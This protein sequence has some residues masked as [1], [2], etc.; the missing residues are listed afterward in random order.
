MAP[1]DIPA[2]KHEVVKH[3][4]GTAGGLLALGEPR[5]ER[6]RQRELHR[7]AAPRR[8]ARTRT[9]TA[10]R[11]WPNKPRFANV[12]K[13]AADKS[14]WGTP[15]P[16]GHFRGMALM[17]GYDTYMAQVAEI[18]MKDGCRWCTR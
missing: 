15:A 16:A 9:P 5:A 6:L 13:I 8:P 4:A 17:E 12:L 14:G 1:Y 7:R 2:T 18:S 11:C 3:D 10:W